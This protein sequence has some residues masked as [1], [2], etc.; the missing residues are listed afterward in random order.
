[1]LD[2]RLF[3]LAM[4]KLL[5][6]DLGMVKRIALL[7]SHLS[8]HTHLPPSQALVELLGVDLGVE[9]PG[10]VQV[11]R[12]QGGGVGEGKGPLGGERG[13]RGRS[14][15]EGRRGGAASSRAVG[16]RGAVIGGRADIA[17]PSE[18]RPALWGKGGDDAPLRASGAQRGARGTW[19]RPREKPSAAD[20]ERDDDD[21]IVATGNKSRSR[22]GP[23]AG[24]RAA[25]W[26]LDAQA[27]RPSRTRTVSEAGV[28]TWMMCV[29]VD[30]VWTWMM[31][32]DVDDV[33]GRG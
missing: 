25:N 21:G 24:P 11:P 27:G 3:P 5:G 14:R 7:L 19:K 26:S 1:M 2:N 33:C 30:D 31:C 8:P 13:K 23:G 10:N 16:R 29:D 20:T 17:G 32:V 22:S 18:R 4:V 12:Q 28:W 6:V 9:A 15:T